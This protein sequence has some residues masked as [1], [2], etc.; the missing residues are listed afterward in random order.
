[1]AIHPGIA[2]DAA[3]LDDDFGKHYSLS[4][5]YFSRLDLNL[6]D[7]EIEQAIAISR[8]KNLLIAIIVFLLFCAVI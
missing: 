7:L 1:M 5:H 2:Y 6:A 8:R 4:R 3:R